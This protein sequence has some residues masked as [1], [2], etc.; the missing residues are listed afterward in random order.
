MLLSKKNSKK[1]QY[2][3]TS[4]RKGIKNEI[5]GKIFYASFIF[6]VGGFFYE[7]L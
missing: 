1:M 5:L 2:F 4:W 3:F 7:L 6:R